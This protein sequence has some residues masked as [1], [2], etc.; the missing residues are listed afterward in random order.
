MPIA[1]YH[2]FNSLR[3]PAAAEKEPVV[4]LARILTFGALMV[5]GGY[6]TLLFAL[7]SR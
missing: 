3:A 7:A 4:R 1:L 2:Y 5:A 6:F